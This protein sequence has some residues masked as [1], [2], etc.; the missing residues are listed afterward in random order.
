MTMEIT[1][2][3]FVKFLKDLLFKKFYGR[4]IIEINSGKIVH[5]EKRESIKQL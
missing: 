5:L 2:E 4:I 1:L 3:G